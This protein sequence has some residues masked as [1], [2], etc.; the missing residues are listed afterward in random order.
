[1]PQDINR[2]ITKLITP[3]ADFMFDSKYRDDLLFEDEH[4]TFVRR[5]FWAYQTL[6]IMNES[7][8]SIVD[9]FEHN[10]TDELWEGA[11]KT[12]WPLAE[13]GSPRSV[14]YKKKMAALRKKFEAQMV[15]FRTLIAGNEE[16]R[17]EIRGESSKR[18]QF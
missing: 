15:K 17:T 10:F 12:L 5:Y 3:S 13:P 8:R 9:E 16:R 18:A 4:F 1:M 6:G 14:Y 2:A 7:I 11:D